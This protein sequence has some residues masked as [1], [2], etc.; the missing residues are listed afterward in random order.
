YQLAHRLRG[1][2]QPRAVNGPGFGNARFLI[3]TFTKADSPRQPPFARI[4]L[5]RFEADFNIDERLHLLRRFDKCN[6]IIA[7]KRAQ[8]VDETLRDLLRTFLALA[9]VD[10]VGPIIDADGKNRLGRRL[11]FFDYRDQLLAKLLVAGFLSDVLD[12]RRIESC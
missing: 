12:Y 8:R 5:H 3:G 7:D 9:F 1:W 6:H 2:V 10:R 4:V 11:E